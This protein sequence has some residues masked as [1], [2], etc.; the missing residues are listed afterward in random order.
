M[1][2]EAPSLPQPRIRVIFG[3]L[4]LVILLAS[5]DQTIV[6][7][8]LPTIVGELGGLQ[9]LSWVVTAY[10]L[11][12][13][14]TGP[15]YGKFGDLYG[16]K[17]VLQ[18]AIVIF[19]VGSALCG[20]SQNMAELIAFRALQGLGAGGLIVTAIAVVG[21]VIPPRDRGR[22]QGI[23]GAVFGVSTII[24]P[25]LGGFFVDNLSWRWIFYVN[26]PVGAV[27]FIVIGAT[28]HSRAVTKQHKIDYFGA[29][30]LAG[31]LSAVVLFTSLGGTTWPWG[32]AQIIALIVIGVAS[33]AAFAFVESR[34][35]EPILPLSLF[36]NRTFAVTSAVGFIVGLSLFGAVTY[37]PLYLQIVKGVSPTK[38][39]LQLTPMMLGLLITSVISGQLIT[40]WGKY[41]IFP[42]IGTAVVSVGMLLLSRLGIGTSLWVAA[43]DMVVLGLGLGMVM[44]VL[45]LA[46][47]NAVDYKHLGVATSGSTMFRSI[48]GSIG[49]SLFGAI[50]SNR[51]HTELAQRL[52][53]SVHLPT[54]TT[55]ATIRALPTGVR[56]SYIHGLTAALSPV[57]TVAAVISFAS[58]VLA[59]FLPDI[60]LKRTS[61]AEGIG[62][63]FATPR[64]ADSELE[65]ERVLSVIARREE[66]WRAYEELAA[67]AQIDLPPAELW[68]LAR[69]GERAPAS[70]EEI[71]AATGVDDSRLHR[72]LGELER[73]GLVREVD[74]AYSLTP[75]GHRVYGTVV[76]VR[77]ATLEELVRDWSPEDHAE[78][79]PVLDRLARSLASEMPTPA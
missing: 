20:L 56:D 29:A 49:V 63:T 35:P 40:R 24:G 71:A 51:L 66:R 32:S 78:L 34:V 50:F 44:Q 14:V 75:E 52:P 6:S 28:F 48:G 11:A 70:R 68:A 3:A 4:M 59:L 10:L 18:T 1:A 47:Q 74:G 57:F 54:T 36:R 60:Q 65:V 19:L 7:T 23:F 22:Y 9:H 69:L 67:N 8:A 61:E 58:F 33:L 64:N 25:L 73:R 72:A 37:L 41:R 39:G 12:S 13:T 46:V 17:I 21:D 30:L 5:L 79:T 77:R 16:R 15:L 55:P 31:G 42:I 2:A 27:A 76:A 53:P 45:V 26:L 62:E 43:L 38:S